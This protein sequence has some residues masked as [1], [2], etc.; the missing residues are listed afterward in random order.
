MSTAAERRKARADAYVTEARKQIEGGRPFADDDL[1]VDPDEEQVNIADHDGAWV[2][3]WVWIY[4]DDAKPEHAVAVLELC[5]SCGAEVP[6][7][8]SCE[9][10]NGAGAYCQACVAKM[11][12]AND[13]LAALEAFIER[14][15]KLSGFPAQYDP[16]VGEILKA[17]EAIAKTRKP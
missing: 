17:K 9:A 16:W 10:F 5:A 1:M 2:R 3:A 13:L 12:V 14:A 6:E 4:E 7:G 15:N 11:L 8:E